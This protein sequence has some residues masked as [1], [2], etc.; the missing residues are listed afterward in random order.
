M[1]IEVASAAD[2]EG[3]TALWEAAGL[4]RPWNNLLRDFD[5]ALSN[6]Q[7]TMFVA[8]SDDTYLGAVMTADDG[9]CGWIYLLG[10]HPEHEGKGVGTA[11]M[12][13]GEEWLR[14]RGQELVFLMVRDGNEQVMD[15][16]IALGYEKRNVQ[17]MGKDLGQAH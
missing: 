8:K 10:V 15:F 13:A 16:Y 9:R 14:K 6:P 17:V 12:K 3:V 11:L 4:K 7:Q 2:S 5:R 1:R